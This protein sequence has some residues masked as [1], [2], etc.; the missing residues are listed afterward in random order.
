M[1]IEQ[2]FIR[3]D[4]VTLLSLLIYGEA[5]GESLTGKQAV[6]HTVMNRVA[7]K[8]RWWG[9]TIQTVCLCP[10]QY[11]CFNRTD[12]NYALLR[13]LAVMTKEERLKVYG[14]KDC[15]K[16]AAVIVAGVEPDNTFGATHYCTLRCH[17]TWEK[18]L[19]F[20]CVIDNH[21]F[22]RT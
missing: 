14:Y 6:A 18:D 5:R 21:K 8:V 19:T 13:N 22:F 10:H 2:E 7:S 16:V 20:T 1:A 17:P 15:L 12:S 11:S 9:S 3:L 4:D